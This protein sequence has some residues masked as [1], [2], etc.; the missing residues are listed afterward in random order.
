MEKKINKRP[1]TYDELLYKVHELTEKNKIL[2]I[3]NTDYD[4]LKIKYQKLEKD[5]NYLKKF[6][7]IPIQEL[8]DG[9][10]EQIVKLNQKSQIDSVK[11]IKLGGI[12]KEAKKITIAKNQRGS[13]IWKKMFG[14]KGKFGKKCG[15]CKKDIDHGSHIYRVLQH[16]KICKEIATTLKIEYADLA[17]ENTRCEKTKNIA[18]KIKNV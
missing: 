11:I 17:L 1:L 10:T 16:V 3:E 4:A 12:A 8:T 18:S 14:D 6:H 2:T 15:Y 13:P 7:A 5:F 9:L